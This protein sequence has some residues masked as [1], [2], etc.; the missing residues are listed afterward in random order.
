MEIEK[1]FNSSL[2]TYNETTIPGQNQSLHFPSFSW[3][4]ARLTICS[5]GIVANSFVIFLITLSSLRTSVFMNLVMILAI[6]DTLHQLAVINLEKG[7]FGQLLTGTS[8]VQ[9]SI[10]NY[11][12][13]VCGVV[14]SWVTVI[15]SL[16]RF[17]AIY[18]PFKVRIYC[19]KK[20]SCVIVV[21]LL[22]ISGSCLVPLLYITKVTL[23]DKGPKCAIIVNGQLEMLFLSMLYILYSIVPALFII[24]VNIIIVRKLKVRRAFKVGSQMQHSKHK[25]SNNTSQVVIMVLISS[26]FVATSFPSTIV[27]FVMLL[28][29]VPGKFF[30]IWLFR[31][32]YLLDDFNHSVNLFL[33]CLPGSLFRHALLQ[34]VRCKDKKSPEDRSNP[35]IS[36][37][38]S[39]L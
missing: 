14:S 9:C 11:I 31:F 30:P 17:I 19:T 36:I 8:E 20:R 25:T 23:T 29:Y 10:T 35:Q 22:I 7:T 4:I 24:F 37:S 34:I 3:T 6:F 1:T 26:V 15:I 18:F 13:Y 32:A 28:T 2:F 33:Y 21:A 5:V 38:Q 27:M 16:E 39:V 12:L